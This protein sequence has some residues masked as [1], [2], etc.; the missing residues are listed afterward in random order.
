MFPV[1]SKARVLMGFYTEDNW[2]CTRS[3]E[4]WTLSSS[5]F[6]HFLRLGTK[7]MTRLK[8]NL[9]TDSN[10]LRRPPN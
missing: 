8:T 6:G 9:G 7:V 5:V 1:Y 3:L 2:S 4:P 10:C